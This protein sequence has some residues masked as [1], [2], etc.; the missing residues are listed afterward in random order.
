MHAERGIVVVR[1]AG[2]HAV[3]ERD[4][5]HAPGDFREKRADLLAA[6]AVPLELPLGCLQKNPF[7]AGSILDFRVT[8]LGELLAM[9]AIE[10]GVALESVKLPNT[11]A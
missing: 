7:V 1:V 11:H 3:D 6:L 8:S 5:I 9:V 4:V 2:V 10:R